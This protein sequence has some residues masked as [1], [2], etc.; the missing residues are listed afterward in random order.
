MKGRGVDINDLT[1][2]ASTVYRKRFKA[3]EGM[4]A[5]I[6]EEVLLRING[7]SLIIHFDTKKV[8][9]IEDHRYVNRTGERLAL[10]VS[11]LDYEKLDVLFG[12]FE[13]SSSEGS[14]QADAIWEALCGWD[15]VDQIIGFCCFTTSSNTGKY[16]GVC[17]ILIECLPNPKLYFTYVFSSNI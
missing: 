7:L 5:Q 11:S 8:D 4:A 9:Q 17:T 6:R 13:I 10:N 16:S 12:I 15:I 1:L 3:V 2:S 14:D